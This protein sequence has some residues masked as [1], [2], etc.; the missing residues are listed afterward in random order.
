MAHH[1]THRDCQPCC[2]FWTV[3]T[4]SVGIIERLGQFDQIATP[5]LNVFCWPLSQGV[6]MCS[7][8]IQQLDVQVNTKTKDNVTVVLRIAVQYRVINEVIPSQDERAGMPL[9]FACTQHRWDSATGLSGAAHTQVC[10]T[11]SP[12]SPQRKQPGRR[13]T[14]PPC[15]YRR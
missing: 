6:G 8:R 7:T 3:S 9:T 1:R 4:G 2:C 15:L 13:P 10:P 5:G 14:T 11:L 12:R